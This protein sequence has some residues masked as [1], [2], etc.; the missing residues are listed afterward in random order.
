MP[1]KILLQKHKQKGA[2]VHW[3]VGLVG[4][5]SKY[6]LWVPGRCLLGYGLVQVIVGGLM[7]AQDLRG[8]GAQMKYFTVS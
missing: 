4:G 7:V 3:S 6:V 8:A 5:A 1:A 2:L